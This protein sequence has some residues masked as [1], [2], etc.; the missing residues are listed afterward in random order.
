MENNS[1]TRLAWFKIQAL[2]SI[3]AT[4]IMIHDNDVVL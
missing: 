2:V 4:Q 1:L 3:H